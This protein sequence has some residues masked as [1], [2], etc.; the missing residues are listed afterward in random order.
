MLLAGD[1]NNGVS[2]MTFFDT[3]SAVR[4]KGPAEVN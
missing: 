4:S 2:K 3:G 1:G